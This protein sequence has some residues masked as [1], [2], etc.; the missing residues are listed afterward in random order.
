M[1]VSF[2]MCVCWWCCCFPSV[3]LPPHTMPMHNTMLLCSL[4][5]F[6]WANEWNRSHNVKFQLRGNVFFPNRNLKNIHVC[7]HMST[8]R[9]VNRERSF[10]RGFRT[11][12]HGYWAFGAQM[13]VE[14]RV[15]YIHIMCVCASLWF[16]FAG[17]FDEVN[18]FIYCQANFKRCPALP[19]SLKGNDILQS[20]YVIEI[21]LSFAWNEW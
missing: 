7:V 5:H 6:I 9:C 10:A 1:C 14:E 4:I 20:V 8:H 2:N 18:L 3:S 17:Y 19:I 15:I 11:Y 13:Y 12:M 21:A 16:D